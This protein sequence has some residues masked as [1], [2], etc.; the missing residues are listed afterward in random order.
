[1]SVVLVNW[2]SDMKGVLGMAPVMIRS[3]NACTLRSFVAFMLV[4]VDLIHTLIIALYIHEQVLGV[5]PQVGPTAFL[6]CMREAV[7]LLVIFV[8][9]SLKLSLLS[10]V[11]P[12]NLAEVDS[13][14]VGPSD[15]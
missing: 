9:C 14:I 13:P 15:L 7:A 3:A 6:H 5:S 8:M 1:M 11:T 12:R 10:K 2:L 4:R